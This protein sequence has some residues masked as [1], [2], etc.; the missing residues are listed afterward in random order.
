MILSFLNGGTAYTSTVVGGRIGV[1]QWKEIALTET[2]SFPER[3]MAIKMIS[4][5]GNT[6]AS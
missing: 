5:L 6:L 4:C 3:S 2:L 1:S